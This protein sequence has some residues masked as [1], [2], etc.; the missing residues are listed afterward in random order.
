MHVARKWRIML[1]LKEMRAYQAESI[2]RG[3]FAGCVIMAAAGVAREAH[4]LGGGAARTTIEIISVTL[5]AIV[6]AA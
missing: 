4:A 5:V 1:G 2:S 6:A 3:H